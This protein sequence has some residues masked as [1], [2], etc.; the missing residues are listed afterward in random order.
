MDCTILGI[1]QALTAVSDTD[2]LVRAMG[3]QH[4]S[5]DG[6]RELAH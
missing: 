4:L 5:T 3:S 6:E 1:S 2:P